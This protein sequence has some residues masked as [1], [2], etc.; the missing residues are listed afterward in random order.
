MP[1]I[2]G[3]FLLHNLLTDHLLTASECAQ[4]RYR[5]VADGLG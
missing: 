5:A 2:E 1:H 3:A 4:H